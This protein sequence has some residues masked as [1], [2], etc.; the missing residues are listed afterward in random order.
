MLSTARE[1]PDVASPH[2]ASS[3]QK[4]MESFQDRSASIVTTAK[5]DIPPSL[6]RDFELFILQ[7]KLKKA[8]GPGKIRSQILKVNALLIARAIFALWEAVG[9]IGYVPA[10]LRS[11][12]YA[13]ILK[14]GDASLSTNYSLISLTSVLRLVILTAPMTRNTESATLHPNQ[15]GF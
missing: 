5:I 12:V 1:K 6:E 14:S 9:R 3:F 2:N 4:F 13:P 11:A 7:S 15:W 10:V 8:P